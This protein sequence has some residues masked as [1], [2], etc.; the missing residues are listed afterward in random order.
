[1]TLDAVESQNGRYIEKLEV[2]Q[3][4]A[5]HHVINSSLIPGKFL[6]FPC[7]FLEF[8]FKSEPS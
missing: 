4:V 1:M 6:G 3:R 5:F 8:R 7:K 2:V